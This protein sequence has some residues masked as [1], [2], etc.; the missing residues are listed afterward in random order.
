MGRINKTYT[1]I[2][3][4]IIAI[5]CLTALTAKPADAQTIPK[6]SVPT[7]TVALIDSSYDIPPTTSVN[8][9]NGEVTTEEGRHV[10]SRTIQVSVKNQPFTPFSINNKTVY[11]HYEVHWKG[12][13]ETEWHQEYYPLDNHYLISIEDARLKN[14]YSVFSFKDYWPQDAQIDFQVKARIGYVQY[15]TSGAA[16]GL[17]G[18]AFTG[19]E[20]DWSSTQTINLLQTPSQPSS[21]PAIPEVSWLAIVPMFL[22]LLSIAWAVKHRKSCK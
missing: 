8:P 15:D 13:F 5:S 3:T 16:G 6:P 11:L 22:S 2:L 10:E 7:F 9:Y 4:L 20:S 18:L 12:H 14:E 19:E 1:I 17:A 21:S